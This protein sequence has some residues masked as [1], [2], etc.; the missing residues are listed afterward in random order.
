MILK[1][2]HITGSVVTVHFS[3]IPKAFKDFC[4]EAGCPQKVPIL[5]HGEY[6]VYNPNDIAYYIDKEW[7]EPDIKSTNEQANKVGGSLFPK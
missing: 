6:V 3:P 5:K 2:K 7:P 4:V 1:L